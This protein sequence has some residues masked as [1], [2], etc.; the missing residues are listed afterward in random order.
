MSLESRRPE[1]SLHYHN[2]KI[3]DSFLSTLVPTETVNLLTVRDVIVQMRPGC[4]FQVKKIQ[5]L[6]K[7]VLRMKTMKYRCMAYMSMKKAVNFFG[8]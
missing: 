7:A 2:L 8:Y 5:K 1:L 4:A 3:N 6:S